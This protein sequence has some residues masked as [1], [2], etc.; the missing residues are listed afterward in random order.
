LLSADELDDYT[1][2]L[3]YRA[4]EPRGGGFEA[5]LA[6]LQGATDATDVKRCEVLTSVLAGIFNMMGQGYMQRQFE[7]SS[8]PDI[9]YSLAP[10]LPD[11]IRY[12]P[13]TKTR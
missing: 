11:L 9:R 8:A 7:F 5:V 10:S 2:D 12:S 4:N 1:R 13:P 6:R 3:L